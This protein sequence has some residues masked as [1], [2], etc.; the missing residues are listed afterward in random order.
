MSSCRARP[1]SCARPRPPRAKALGP[2][3]RSTRSSTFAPASAA[4]AGLRLRAEQFSVRVQ[5]HR[6][7]RLR[8]GHRGRQPGDRQGQHVAPRHDAAAGRGGARRGWRVRPAAGHRAIALSHRARRRRAAGRRPAHRRHGLHRQPRGAGS[9]SRPRPIAPASRSIW[10]CRASIR[11][12][13]CPARWPSGRRDRRR[14]HHKL[15]DGHGPV[16]H[17]SRTGDV[18]GRR[19][20]RRISSPSWRSDFERPRSARCLSRGVAQS[21]G[22]QRRA[23]DRRR[24]RSA[25][26][27][28]NR[29]AGDAHRFANTLLARL[30]PAS[31]LP[32]PRRCR[33]RPSA[34]RRCSSSPTIR[35][36]RPACSSSSKAI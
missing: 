22:R 26:R 15:P 18:A 21:L 11:S 3:R 34:M 24:G 25:R 23:I 10:N 5:Q 33:P 9:R 13:C 16:L 30:G 19:G 32:I 27:R 17:Q 2:C 14:V 29:I 36:R 12:S 4:G 1:A 6:R 35:A 7:R 8:R 31:F 20:D 28:R